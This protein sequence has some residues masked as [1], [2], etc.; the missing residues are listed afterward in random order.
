MRGCHLLV[1]PFFAA[2]FFG[3]AHQVA[4][5][6]VLFGPGTQFVSHSKPALQENQILAEFSFY[7]D[8]P[9]FGA[10]VIAPGTDVY[11]LTMGFHSLDM[12]IDG[13][14]RLCEI[15][16][17]QIYEPSQP[18]ILVATKIPKGLD[19][20]E[21]WANGRGN[22]PSGLGQPSYSVFVDEYRAKAQAEGFSA[23]AISSFAQDGYATG[24]ATQAEAEDRAIA[25]CEAAVAASLVPY[26]RDIREM[27]RNEGLDRCHVFDSQGH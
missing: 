11:A 27:I 24:F 14:L 3:A 21:I 20:D 2:T 22:L 18:C 7:V 1:L 6:P 5:E 25:E 12:A 9:Y 26:P 4:A 8:A 10:F 15:S 16:S 13:A 17:S 19:S 23:F